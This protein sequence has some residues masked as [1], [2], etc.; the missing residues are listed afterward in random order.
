V[1][2][3]LRTLLWLAV[4]TVGLVAAATWLPAYLNRVQVPPDFEDIGGL[5]PM[6]GV[7]LTAPPYLAGDVVAYRIG[8]GPEDISFAIVAGLPG[9]EVRLSAGVLL[10]DGAEVRSWKESGTYRGIHDIGPLTVPA[11]HLYVI[12]KQHMHDSLALGVLA[13]EQLLGKVRQ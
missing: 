8:D 5:T 13:P 4:L 1:I 12:S 2:W 9:N 11:N 3:A 6:T 10:V 7:W